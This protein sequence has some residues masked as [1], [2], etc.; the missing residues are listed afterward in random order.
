MKELVQQALDTAR[1]RG[2]SF[3][4]A[5]AQRVRT[6]ALV[7]K[8]GRVG[9]IAESE[10]LGIGVR[11]IASGAWGFASTHDLSKDGIDAAAG[12]AVAIA[13]ASALCRR[14]EVRLAPLTPV[15]AT[16]RTKIEIDPFSIPVEEKIALL[17]SA[18]EAARRTKGIT[19]TEGQMQFAERDQ[20]CLSTEGAEIHQIT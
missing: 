1:A 2:A 10:S 3:A 12:R 18:E 9:S 16:W 11:V 6:Q 5:R 13:R 4:D 20:W 15:R 19:V 8:N 17:L 7:V 14:G